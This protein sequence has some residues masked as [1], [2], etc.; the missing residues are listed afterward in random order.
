M[1]ITRSADH[2][3]ERLRVLQDSEILLTGPNPVLDAICQEATRHFEVPIGLVTL[4]DCEKLWVKALQGL[5]ASE[6]PRD[7][8]FCA[9]TILSDD[10]FVIPDMLA[11]ERF[12]TNPLALGEPRLRFYA[13]LLHGWASW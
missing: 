1:H 2:E 6:L 4:V 8:A 11:D 3:E 7:T 9:Y 12:K 13:A 5:A 10:V